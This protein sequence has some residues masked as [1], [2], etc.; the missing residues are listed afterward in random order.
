MLRFIAGIIFAIIVLA[1]LAN[2]KHNS[3][4]SVVS[5]NA[6]EDA[7]LING[8]LDYGVVIKAR[9]KLEGGDRNATVTSRLETSNGDISKSVSIGL[10]DGQ[11]RE[12]Q[13]QF[14]E[15]VLGTQFGNY[16]T[17]CS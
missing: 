9:V 4:C 5:H 17:S 15:P 8:Q 12:V 16:Y 11:T 6:E 3:T 10:R 14:P 1:Y 2:D 7:F 13:L